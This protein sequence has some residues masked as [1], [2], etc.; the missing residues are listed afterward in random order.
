M[1]PAPQSTLER[2]DFSGGFTDNVFDND[3]TRC[4]RNDNLLV[5][6]NRKLIQRPGSEILD[7]GSYQLPTGESRVAKIFQFE[8]ESFLLAQNGKRIFYH[9]QNSWKEILGPDG[10]SALGGD[11]GESTQISV[12]PWKGH[13]FITDNRG[14]RPI[15]IYMDENGSL[16]VRTAGLPQMAETENFTLST[17]ISQAQTL[18]LELKTDMTSHMNNIVYH[19]VAD[20]AALAMLGSTPTL[21]GTLPT[22]INYTYYLMLGYTLHRST[23][24]NPS[25]IHRGDGDFGGQVPIATQ[26]MQDL[27]NT[28]IPE[29]IYDVVDRLNDLRRTYN[30]H[31]GNIDIHDGNAGA[32]I[33][34]SNFISPIAKGPSFTSPLQA[35][36]SYANQIKTN[37]NAHL[38][39]G[40]AVGKP[41]STLADPNVVTAADATTPDTLEALTWAIVLAYVK[42]DQ[43]A[44]TTL[45]YHPAVETSDHSFTPDFDNPGTA[46]PYPDWLGGVRAGF[47]EEILARL[48][49][50]VLKYNAHALD[51]GA[52]YTT[53]PSFGGSF[54][55]VAHTVNAA[56]LSLANYTYAF[57]Y[58]Y[59]YQVKDVEFVVRG[60]VLF[61]EAF[62]VMSIDNEGLDVENIPILRQD[63][64]CYDTANVVI[65]V[66]R[67]RNNGNIYY[68]VTELDNIAD[69]VSDFID[70]VTDSELITKELLYTTGGIL[71]N[72][73]PPPAKCFHIVNN[74]AYYGHVT[75]DGEIKTNRVRQ[76][77]PNAP[78]SCPISLYVDLPDEVVGV[79]SAKQFP[80]VGCKNSIHRLEGVMDELGQGAINHL[81]ISTSVGLVSEQSLVQIE[82]GLL[83]AGTDGFYF[84]DGYNLVKI[85]ELWNSTYREL[86]RV[87]GG[88]K[89]ITGAYDKL[90]RQVWWAAQ[91]SEDSLDNDTCFIL[92]LDYGLKGDSCWSTAS[93]GSHFYPSSLAFYQGD[94]IRGDS[95]G[96]VFR[97]DESLKSDPYVNPF[98]PAT[99]W[100]KTTTIVDYRSCILD[101][102]SSSQTKWVPQ[103]EIQL[104]NHGNLTLQPVSYNDGSKY[105][106]DLAVIKTRDGV[107]WGDPTIVWGDHRILWNHRKN[108]SLKRRFP[109][110][111]LRCIYKQLQLTNGEILIKDSSQVGDVVVDAVTKQLTLPTG[112]WIRDP[113]GYVIT[114]SLDDYDT[115]FEI[116]Q[117]I[118]D[119]VIQVIDRADTLVTG[120]YAWK[121][122]GSPK[123]EYFHL[124]QYSL[125]GFGIGKNQEGARSEA[126]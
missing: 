61:K 53:N 92:N 23:A 107:T 2:L 45:A 118:S 7:S 82:N 39:D 110:K 81:P 33:V 112:S 12:S 52:H 74:T 19:S 96:Y 10:N 87:I 63:D 13:L 99:Q 54:T 26:A 28:Q 93:G 36:Y 51:L 35:I 56:P 78:Y 21:D 76:S 11:G 123:G 48:N 109:A 75:E 34:T 67:T 122:S 17:V 126:T 30:T 59:T 55:H 31:S 69:T 89:F 20:T 27:D 125:V 103:M 37:L 85:S 57:L 62:G 6:D 95:R 18:A 79:S 8:D 73:P 60:P 40:G 124:L 77:I 42:H 9:D 113:L 68:K 22:L 38:Q 71:D 86:L 108:L 102:G 46:P 83:F 80:I 116:S 14:G 100:G 70:Y 101:F 16:Q 58:K 32:D 15:Q 114:L 91:A 119:Q 72:D 49:L 117:R 44:E 94:L 104:R 5:D 111:G 3:P 65:E 115:E 29:D 50:V 43:D 84:T 64:T 41:H 24:K 1:S 97:H 106:K 88:K 98:I 105:G 66:Y 25:N 120:T 47:Y 4:A 90:N 121:I